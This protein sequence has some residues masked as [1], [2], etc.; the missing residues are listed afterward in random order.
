MGTQTEQ[1]VA[2]S[3]QAH[4]E[5]W[6]KGYR[7]ENVESQVFRVYGR[8]LRDQLG[9]DGS[10]G[11]K[12]LDFGCGEGAALEFFQ[13]KGFNV[14]GVDISAVDIDRCKVKMPG[15]ADQ[16]SVI[17]PKPSADAVFF[18]GDYDVVVSIQT[19]HYFTNTVMK[20]LLASIYNQ[21]KKGAV[22]YTTVM[23]SK[24]TWHRNNA[25]L[26]G[27]GLWKVDFKN[28]RIEVKDYYV[29]FVESEEHLVER[30]SL[31]KPLHT[32]YYSFR[33]RKDELDEH[34]YTFVGVKE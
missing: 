16:F 8:I 3:Y 23:A 33:Y 20:D 26:Q 4:T 12:L 7:A 5:Y 11:E 1:Y 21:M 24:C 30:F 9:I 14:H 13:K 31:F 10:K 6:K 28:D 17:D 29:N 18:G 15:I 19:M 34:F 27:D 25:V 22:L 32:G 2:D